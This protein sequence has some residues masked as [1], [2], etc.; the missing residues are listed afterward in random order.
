MPE[1][2]TGKQVE[3]FEAGVRH[4]AEPAVGIAGQSSSL[5]VNLATLAIDI[6]IGESGR[7]ADGVGDVEVGTRPKPA[8]INEGEGRDGIMTA[9]NNYAA[10]AKQGFVGSE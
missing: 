6:E 9:M 2:F 10:A 5:F 1:L 7:T 8:V 3:N 4:E